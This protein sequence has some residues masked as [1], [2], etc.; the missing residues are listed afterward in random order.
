MVKRTR[1]LLMTVKA[2]NDAEDKVLRSQRE[3]DEPKRRAPSPN[4]VQVR[5]NGGLQAVRIAGA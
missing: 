4:A 3:A 2:T 1:D 5:G